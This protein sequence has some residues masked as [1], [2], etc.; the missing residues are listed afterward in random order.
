MVMRL[1]R[2]PEVPQEDAADALAVALAGGLLG[3]TPSAAPRVAAGRGGA[4]GRKAWEA[5]VKERKT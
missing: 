3:D 5:F 4:K 1:L 2:L